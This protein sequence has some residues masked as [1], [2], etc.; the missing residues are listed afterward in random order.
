M[1]LPDLGS[2]TNVR[3]DIFQPHEVMQFIHNSLNWLYQTSEWSFREG[4]LFKRT[5]LNT[6]EKRGYLSTGSTALS[7]EPQV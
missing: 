1:K 6:A 7:H 4:E 3:F 2:C 5:E